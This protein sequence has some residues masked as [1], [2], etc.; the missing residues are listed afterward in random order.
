MIAF[1]QTPI[2]SCSKKTNKQLDII[3]NEFQ[4]QV[5]SSI[6]EVPSKLLEEILI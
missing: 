6:R 5:L 1:S 3:F 4:I 2:P